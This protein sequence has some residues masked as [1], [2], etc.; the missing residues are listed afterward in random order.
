MTAA[1]VSASASRISDG[2]PTDSQ[3]LM[4]LGQNSEIPDLDRSKD[5][6]IA[7]LEGVGT[8][9][10][11]DRTVTLTPGVFVFVPAGIP[12]TLKVQTTL[13]LL[14]IDCEAD[15]DM[16]ESAWLMNFQL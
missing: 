15:P 12:R 14:L 4:S 2:Q 13:N 16:S 9:T 3:K 1:I 10:V 8:L 6:T 11:C 7:V 5:V